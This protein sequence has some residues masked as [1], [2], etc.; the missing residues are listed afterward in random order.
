MSLPSFAKIHEGEVHNFEISKSKFGDILTWAERVKEIASTEIISKMPAP[1]EYID[2]LHIQ[3]NAFVTSLI[4]LMKAHIFFSYS[5]ARVGVEA[6]TRMATIETNFERHLKVWQ[7]HNYAKRHSSEFRNAKRDFNRVFTD[8]RAKH[9]YS[10]FMEE[11]EYRVLFERWD[12][13]SECGSHAGFIQ[14]IFSMVHEKSG[15]NESLKSGIFDVNENDNN[16]IGKCMVYIIDTFF[17]C[18]LICV[19][20]LLRH[21]LNLKRSLQNI[22]SL[23]DEWIEFKL[24]K[25]QEFGIKSPDELMKRSNI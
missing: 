14:T 1:Q 5:V 4:L 11:D 24:A 15:E 3:G 16:Q 7:K 19:R 10:A 21:D 20:I 25:A 13:L 9:D 18:A 12:F 22:E 8:P 6:T 17:L 23:M 2:L